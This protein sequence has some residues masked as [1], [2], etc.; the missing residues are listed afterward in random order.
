MKLAKAQHHVGQLTEAKQTYRTLIESE[1]SP[2][3]AL[4]LHTELVAVLESEE[5]RDTQLL[6]QEEVK[7][8]ESLY[9][10][11]SHSL[12]WSVERQILAT[13]FEVER[14]CFVHFVSDEVWI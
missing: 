6:R 11:Q 13:H 14:C 8:K 3:V 4:T 10:S 2:L 12:D 5:E 1:S 9:T 7:N